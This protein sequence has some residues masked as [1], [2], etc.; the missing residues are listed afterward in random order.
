MAF[1]PED[2]SGKP[3]ANSLGSVGQIDDYF[4]TRGQ[5]AWAGLN[6]TDEAK[7]AAL[8]LATDYICAEYGLEF[9][10]NPA[11]AAQSLPFPRAQLV[12]P[13]SGNYYP[14][15]LVPGP[16]LHALFELA[17][18]AAEKKTLYNTAQPSDRQVIKKVTG[19]LETEW[20]PRKT[21]EVTAANRYPFVRQLLQPMLKGSGF[22]L[23][24]R[25]V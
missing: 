20:Q 21:D 13:R 14:T 25:R 9:K 15:D 11:N 6:A 8:I 2:G 3:D 19:P 1:T 17:K 10:G 24:S 18:I 12:D 23:T 4:N 7:Q 22:T 5:P 16:V